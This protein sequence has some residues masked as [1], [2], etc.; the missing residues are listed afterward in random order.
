MWKSLSEEERQVWNGEAEK[1][2][3]EH[4]RLYPEYKYKP[5][6]P[7]P[8]KKKTLSK[9]EITSSTAEKNCEEIADSILK[10]HGHSGIIRSAEGKPTL[11]RT[12]SKRKERSAAAERA[13]PAKNSRRNRSRTATGGTSRS[14][15]KSISRSTR[16]ISSDIQSNAILSDGA[17][18][19]SV[20]E[21]FYAP[22]ELLWNRTSLSKGSHKP[23]SE[24]AY[25]PPAFPQ[26]EFGDYSGLSN[27]PQT[28]HDVG[29]GSS[30]F[31]G[32]SER[33][34]EAGV[35]EGQNQDSNSAPNSASLIKTQSPSSLS[36]TPR[37]KERPQAFNLE[38]LSSATSFTP[39]SPTSVSFELQGGGSIPT[40]S[41]NNFQAR[42]ET[43]G[44]LVTPRGITLW[45]L[46]HRGSASERM[47]ISPLRS[48]FGDI[49]KLSASWSKWDKQLEA[50]SIPI[51]TRIRYS[52]IGLHGNDSAGMSQSI[53]GETNM[54]GLAGIY[55]D[56]SGDA[57]FAQAAQEAAATLHADSLLSDPDIDVF[58]FR[59]E[60]LED[61]YL[62]GEGDEG[63]ARVATGTSSRRPDTA[64]NDDGPPQRFDPDMTWNMKTGQTRNQFPFNGSVG[65]NG[66]RRRS[67]IDGI[68]T[69]IGAAAVQAAEKVR[70][71]S[72]SSGREAADLNT[73]ELSQQ[74]IRR[75]RASFSNNS[76]SALQPHPSTNLG[77]LSEEISSEAETNQSIK[78]VINSSS[79]GNQAL[80]TY[81]IDDTLMFDAGQVLYSI[82]SETQPPAQGLAPR[83]PVDLFAF[84]NL[85]RTQE[86]P[87]VQW[88]L[89]GLQSLQTPVDM[90]LLDA[91]FTEL[92]REGF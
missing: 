73:N 35:A 58:S 29:G 50:S 69:A 75:W 14:A 23:S 51:P 26:G 90:S 21:T 32:W 56:E 79:S 7:P 67:V 42:P 76:G 12:A 6:P 82:Q 64:N 27:R 71:D 70:K 33:L 57:L 66:D 4:K 19:T 13:A 52:Q 77:T 17:L 91:A 87:P 89:Y 55:G 81:H 40:F 28:S 61:P 53:P 30:L 48:S 68:K 92:E 36:Q 10:A 83:R 41:T 84:M 74:L 34:R 11:S 16:G 24:G 45:N 22:G 31:G 3:A 59:P 46:R 44:G 47:L 88:N 8:G 37:R 80:A 78:N 54:E 25:S 18:V 20:P 38:A 62:E 65:L 60:F 2:K 85:D 39:L 86:I 5:L 43:A 1:E 9:S 49:R 63:L 15:E 72:L